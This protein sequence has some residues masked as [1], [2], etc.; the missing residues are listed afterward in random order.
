MARRAYY[1]SQREERWKDATDEYREAFTV[2]EAPAY[3][4]SEAEMRL[5]Q[6]QPA[7]ATQ[8]LVPL[9]SMTMK[10]WGERSRVA[11][12]QWIA[13]KQA[14]EPRAIA[15]AEDALMKLFTERPEAGAP[16]T[17]VDEALRELA[18]GKAAKNPLCLRCAPGLA[19]VD[20]RR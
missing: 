4:L 11:L 20:R 8:A 14:N 19:F 12:L 15:E 18:C 9:R 16:A 6:K 10:D 17:P 1:W 7:K 5:K 13:A 3:A 2:G